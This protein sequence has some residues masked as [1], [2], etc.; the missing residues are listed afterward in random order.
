MVEGFVEERYISLYMIGQNNIKLKLSPNVI[1]DSLYKAFQFRPTR[2]EALFELVHYLFHTQNAIAKASKYAKL[3]I[4]I[5]ECS[6]ILFVTTSIYEYKFLDLAF[7]CFYFN[8]EYDIAYK[9]INKLLFQK[10]FPKTEQIRLENNK[11]CCLPNVIN[12]Y[13]IYPKNKIDK[14][15]T[16]ISNKTTP[17]KIMFSI[18]TCKRFNLFQKTM[19]SFINCCTDIHNIDKFICIDDNSSN[20]DRNKMVQLY[21]FFEFV[22]KNELN[23]GH[24]CSMNKIQDLIQVYNP[25]YLIHL[26]DD[27]NFHTPYNYITNAIEILKSDTTLGQLLFNRNYTELHEM[28]DIKIVGGI[29][30][31]KHPIPY[32]EHEYYPRG[33]LKLKNFEEKHKGCWSN[34]YWPHY[35]LRPSVIKCNIFNT[36]GKYSSTNGHFENEYADR[37][38]KHGYKS[39]FFDGIFCSHIGKLTPSRRDKTDTTKNA[40]QLNNI[41]Q[42]SNKILNNK[43]HI[44]I[45]NLVRR[46][47]RKQKCIQMLHDTGIKEYDFV[48][49]VDG[50]QLKPS[51]KLY[52]LFDGNDFNSRKGVIGCAL[53]HYNLWKQLLDDNN[54]EYYV[55]MEDDVTL[56]TNFKSKFNSIKSHFTE[57]DL[58]FLGYSMFEKKR[59]TV[60]HIY[61]NNNDK[62]DISKLQED[63]YIGGFFAYT[64]NK[65]GANKM[66]NYI[67]K[68]GIKHGI[69]Y[70]IKI[71]N[72]DKFECQPLIATSIWNENNISIDTDIQN[73]FDVLDFSQFIEKNILKNYIFI[74]EQDQ[75]GND[76]YHKLRS[77]S[78]MAHIA[79]LD[80]KCIGFN[81]LGFF[82]PLNI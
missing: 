35:S 7:L 46:P 8:K 44:Q 66:I 20:A 69:D 82:T 70:I 79:N 15:Y 49:A 77:I 28:R 54:N 18:T 3:G 43:K 52:K 76:C 1:E 19:N 13:N 17:C 23:K 34:A 2:L 74:P 27:W 67:E 72:I 42:F 58:M 9:T 5:T 32:I 48:D 14:L 55:I 51:F 11:G 31:N 37:Y 59:A 81:T 36:L 26:E 41:D 24:V 29:Y 65:R 6:D 33:S 56:G 45:I 50:Q 16:D 12:S 39:G 22:F 73:N 78:E 4:D 57:K 60:K 47:D 40:Y 53:S 80:E 25:T 64:I 75:I 21:P 62:I 63:L 30:K 10:K 38:V 61:D 68:N 71:A